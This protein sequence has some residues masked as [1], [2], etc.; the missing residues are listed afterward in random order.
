MVD[1]IFLS[2]RN[3]CRGVS[4]EFSGYSPEQVLPLL[5]PQEVSTVCHISGMPIN[6]LGH[7]LFSWGE[8]WFHVD[9]VW[10]Q[11]KVVPHA[12]FSRYLSENAREVLFDRTVQVCDPVGALYRLVERCQYG[13][14]FRPRFNCFSFCEE[15]LGPVADSTTGLQG[16][17]SEL[18]D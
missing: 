10:G 7:W 12:E 5:V 11:V 4:G 17:L 8:M 14:I 6:P 1:G 2:L 9:N 3:Q 15:V 16:S 18:F 13:F